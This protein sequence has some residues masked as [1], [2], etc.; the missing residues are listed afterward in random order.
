M[1]VRRVATDVTQVALNAYANQDVPFARIVEAVNPKRDLSRSPV[2]QTLFTFNNT[3]QA[4]GDDVV[5]GLVTMRRR[6]VSTG[7]A[8]ADLTLLMPRGA[9]GRVMFETN[10][11]LFDAATGSRMLHEFCELL[12]VAADHLDVRID[13]LP[14]TAA[15]A[16]VTVG[17]APTQTGTGEA[18]PYPRDETVTRLF[19][20]Q[21]LR[22]P[23]APVVADGTVLWTYRD[24]NERANRLAHVLSG[25]CYDDHAG[26]YAVGVCLERSADAVVA[27]LAI[28][29]A[30]GA[31]VPLDPLLAPSAIGSARKTR[32]TAADRHG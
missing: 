20:I 2:V 32:A 29:K 5:A 26:P 31:Y 24:L 1:T 4:A 14:A 19:E 16:V 15:S 8:K 17:T 9:A 12:A 10:A 22:T 7:T 6:F 27:L 28:L 30:G 23:D 13:Q 25:R 3:P 18:A 21:A 11:D